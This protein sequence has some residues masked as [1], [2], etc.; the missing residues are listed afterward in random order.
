MVPLFARDENALA[1]DGFDQWWLRSE[2]EIISQAFCQ[3]YLCL[4]SLHSF[5]LS[6]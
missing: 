3:N 4:L 1:V 5:L 2:V 6:L